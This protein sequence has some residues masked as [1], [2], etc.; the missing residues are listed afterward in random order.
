MNIDK[1]NIARHFRR[2]YST[3]EAHAAAQKHISARLDDLLG[4]YCPDRQTPVLEVGCG[5]GLMTAHLLT[6]YAPSDLWVNDLVDSSCSAV[7][8][9]YHIPVGQCLPGDIETMVLPQNF[10]LIVS[11]STFQWLSHPADTFSRLAAYLH[12]EGWLVFSTFGEENCKEVREVTGEGLTYLT[13]QEMSE[14]LASHF[15]VIYMEE[16]RYTLS[17]ANPSEVLRHLKLTGVNAASVARPWTRA[18]LT[19][20]TERYDRFFSVDGICPLTYHPQYFV[21]R[22]RKA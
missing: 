6:H 22:L 17:F 14:L 4:R 9:R 12:S 3:Y 10:H 2:S 1:E 16:E 5:T 11:A 18:A 19:N 13:I 8:A 21:C 20:F 15:E 7:S